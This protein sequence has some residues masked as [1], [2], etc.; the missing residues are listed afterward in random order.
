MTNIIA[1]AI[2]D[3]FVRVNQPGLG[4]SIGQGPGQGL[5]LGLGLGSKIFF[6]VD[7]GNS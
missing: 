4:Q 7:V 6:F 5:G 3:H 2:S 1:T